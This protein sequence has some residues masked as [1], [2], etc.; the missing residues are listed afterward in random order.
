VTVR[1]GMNDL[2]TSPTGLRRTEIYGSDSPL[3]FALAVWFG[4]TTK[5]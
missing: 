3:R 2:G 4:R 1:P 5:R